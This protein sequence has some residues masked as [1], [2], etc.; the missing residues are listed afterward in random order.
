MLKT[1]ITTI[2]TCS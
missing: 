2:H 1:S